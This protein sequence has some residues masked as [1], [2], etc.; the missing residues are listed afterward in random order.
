MRDRSVVFVL[1]TVVAFSV[2]AS[3]VPDTSH[4]S[5]GLLVCVAPGDNTEIV[6]LAALVKEGTWTVQ[7]L[8][9]LRM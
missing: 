9:T 5:G 7:R 1:A 4:A 6:S 3:S 2:N 8:T